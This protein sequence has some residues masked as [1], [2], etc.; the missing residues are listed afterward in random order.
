MSLKMKV[1]LFAAILFLVPLILIPV[2]RAHQ[3]YRLS[4]AEVLYNLIVH[5]QFAPK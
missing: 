3:V 2:H 1:Y 4:Y 5:Q